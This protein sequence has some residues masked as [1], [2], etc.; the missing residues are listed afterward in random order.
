MLYY[1]KISII[2][3]SFNQGQYIEQTILSVIN[4]QYPNLEY[5]I[6]D[7]GSSDNTVDIIKKYESYITYWVSEPDKGQ[8]DALNKGLIKCTGEIFN[9]INSDDY[10]EENALFEIAQAFNKNNTDIVCGYSRI[11]NDKEKVTILEHRTQLF[12][13]VEATMVEQK[14]NQQGM[15]Y[16]LDIIRELGGINPN[17]HYVMDLEL[18]WR[19]L[20]SIGQKNIRLIDKLIAHFRIH[21]DSKTGAFEQR[22]RNEEKAIWFYILNQL[23]IGKPWTD[24]FMGSTLYYPKIWSFKALNEKE[25]KNQIAVK[26]LYTAYTEGK[27]KFSKAAFLQLAKSRNLT[28]SLQSLAIFIKLFIGNIHFRK[29]FKAN[30]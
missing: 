4:Q 12:S 17:L 22:F 18:W 14:I 15:F 26:Y 2:T 1:P 27:I 19:Y 9:W 7:G 20:S 11:F 13:S 10:L 6:I 8:S 28:F 5:I 21:D 25:L 23:D 29:Y 16:R 24:Y 3:P 30:A